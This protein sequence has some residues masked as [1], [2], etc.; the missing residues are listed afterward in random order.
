MRLCSIIDRYPIT[1]P[2]LGDVPIR[3]N[4]AAVGCR[5]VWGKCLAQL[6]QSEAHP[7][8][9]CAQRPAKRCGDGRLTQLSEV[10][11]HKH[12][13]LLS[14]ELVECLQDEVT[15]R[16]APDLLLDIDRRVGRCGEEAVDVLDEGPALL[17]AALAQAGQHLVASNGKQPRG[18]ATA[19][20]I[21]LR[22]ATPETKECLLHDLLGLGGTEQVCGHG[23]DRSVVPIVER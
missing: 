18:K 9:D 6:L 22:G 3:S 14:W 2:N 8:F 21:E 13:A 17:A 7:F 12:T 19:P 11:K 10:S 5:I 23:V 1:W 4:A 16:P 20:L 15:T